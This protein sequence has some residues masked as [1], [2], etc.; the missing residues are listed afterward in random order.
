MNIKKCIKPIVLSCILPLAFSASAENAGAGLMDGDNFFALKIGGN[1]SST[2]HNNYGVKDL[3]TKAI[4][5]VEF[6]R[7]FHDMLTLSAEYI[8]KPKTNFNMDQ[9]QDV[10]GDKM[11]ENEWAVRSDVFMFNAT[12][13]LMQDSKITP[14]V[15]AGI[16]SS[17][18]KSY[19]YKYKNTNNNAYY[20]GKTKNE[21]A[22]QAGAGVNVATSERIDTEIS[23]MFMDRGKIETEDYKYVIGK[24]ITENSSKRSVSL[25]DHSFMV[26]LKV[27][28]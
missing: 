5:G 12:I 26:A 17:K 8:Y 1:I 22:W 15:K 20:P 28:F 19:D 16:G 23:Y 24:K 21:F 4:G 11:T 25:K 18:N 3:D 13:H 6:G 2:D 7:K 14:F 10:S 27:K 9:Y